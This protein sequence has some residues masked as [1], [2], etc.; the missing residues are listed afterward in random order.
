MRRKKTMS[1]ADVLK[2]YKKEM[3]IDNKLKEVELVSSWEE[4]AGQAIARRT[5][6]VYIRKSTLVIHLSSAV[7]RNEL[8]MIRDTLIKRMNEKA[9]ENI[10]DSVEL[11]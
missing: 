2:E 1:V 5:T 9:G 3:N 11:R 4:I 8:L 10:I 6:R 7:V